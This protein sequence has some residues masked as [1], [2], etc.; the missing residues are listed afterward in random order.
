[1]IKGKSKYSIPEEAAVSCEA[2]RWKLHGLGMLGCILT[3]T[4]GHHKQHKERNGEFWDLKYM[5]VLICLS[6]QIV[7]GCW[8]RSCSSPPTVWPRPA[9]AAPTTGWQHLQAMSTQCLRDLKVRTGGCT[10]LDYHS[11]FEPI[12]FLVIIFFPPGNHL[13]RY[14]K[15]LE[16]HLGDPKPR[17]LPACPHLSWAKPQPVNETAPRWTLYWGG[18]AFS[19]LPMW[20]TFFFFFILICQCDTLIT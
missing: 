1:M 19:G 6:G 14:S 20:L 8:T 7:S 16:A 5:N 12:L 3:W 4:A 18:R 17:P 15:V 11:E 13:Y 9:W 10:D 2:W